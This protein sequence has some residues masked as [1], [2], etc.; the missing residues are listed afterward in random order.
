MNGTVSFPAHIHGGTRKVRGHHA[1]CKDLSPEM[2]ISKVK[3]P[4]GPGIG[5][6]LS[7]DRKESH[8]GQSSRQR[9]KGGCREAR[10]KGPQSFN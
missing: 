2:A 1:L 7:Q 9:P 4:S 10:L 8:L 3:A 5:T 6:G